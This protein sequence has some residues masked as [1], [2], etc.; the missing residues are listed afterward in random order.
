MK[1]NKIFF[2]L[3]LIA[4]TLSSCTGDWLETTK[5]GTPNEGNFWKMMQITSKL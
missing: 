1:I 4:G 3:L 5:E 2:S